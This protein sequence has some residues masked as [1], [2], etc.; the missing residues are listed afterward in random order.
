[1]PYEDIFKDKLI[2]KLMILYAVREYKKPLSNS[3]LTKLVTENNEIDFFDLQ[4]GISELVKIGDLYGFEEDGFHFYRLNSDGKDSIDFFE[5]KIP[6]VLRNRIRKSVNAQHE[7]EK[8][9]TDVVTTTVP[10]GDGFLVS[11]KILEDGIEQ[12]G[13]NINVASR[14]TAKA[15][16]E[17]FKHNVGDIYQYVSKNIGEIV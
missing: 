15:T 11:V 14:E 8:P 3:L 10:E 13:V 6:L 5:N 17:Y 9:I 2:I 4:Y 16:C 1:M 12:F 7:K